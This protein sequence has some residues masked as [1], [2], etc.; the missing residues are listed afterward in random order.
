MKHI[1]ES[2]S[3][4]NVSEQGK[5]QVNQSLGELRSTLLVLAHVVLPDLVSNYKQLAKKYKSLRAKHVLLQASMLCSMHGG[6]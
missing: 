3:G 6:R 1:L 5:H 4:I 2:E